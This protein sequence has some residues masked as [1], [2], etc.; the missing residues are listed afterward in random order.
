[1]II[2]LFSTIFAGVMSSSDLENNSIYCGLLLISAA[3]ILI[4]KR[5]KTPSK[6]Q[7]SK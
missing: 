6:N 1:M 2:I 4:K 3:G 7:R 5:T